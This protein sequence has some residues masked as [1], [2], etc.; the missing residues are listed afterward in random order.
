MLLLL[1]LAGVSVASRLSTKPLLL[2][3]DRITTC[4]HAPPLFPIESIGRSVGRSTRRGLCWLSSL[5][6]RE[7]GVRS[8]DQHD[9]T[10]LSSCRD[11]AC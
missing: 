5:R 11:D 4:A 8:L 3:A 6:F 1:A 9:R 7:S 2:M 10:P